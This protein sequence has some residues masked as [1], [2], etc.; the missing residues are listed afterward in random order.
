MYT[1]YKVLSNYFHKLDHSCENSIIKSPDKPVFSVAL[2]MFPLVE[3]VH[4]IS[5]KLIYDIVLGIT[6]FGKHF[7]Q[8]IS[9]I[10]VIHLAVKSGHILISFLKVYF[11]EIYNNIKVII[12]SIHFY[13]FFVIVTTFEV[14]NNNKGLDLVYLL[15]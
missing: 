1:N 9:A 10:I 3:S 11:C 12:V 13:I 5:V 8:N 4:T 14:Q 6:S 2:L 15:Q 7:Y